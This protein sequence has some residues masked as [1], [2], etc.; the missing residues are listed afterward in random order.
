MNDISTIELEMSH[1]M[2][3]QIIQNYEEV[4]VWCHRML[5]YKTNTPMKIDALIRAM[6]LNH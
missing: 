4:N 2:T 5:L 6:Y 1:R 3:L